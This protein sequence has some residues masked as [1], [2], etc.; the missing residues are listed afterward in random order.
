MKARM[1][2]AITG[3]DL[4][5]LERMH[6]NDEIREKWDPVLVGLESGSLVCAAWALDR[7]YNTSAPGG[8]K[9]YKDD[10]LCVRVFVEGV[11]LAR[12]CA[13]ER[14]GS[15]C[16]EHELGVRGALKA[17][18]RLCRDTVGLVMEYVVH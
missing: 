14:Q 13:V 15:L 2:S 18:G 9:M 16:P 11:C 12:G 5:R 8:L 10:L 17:S 1:M 6:N 7:G 4:E 3:R